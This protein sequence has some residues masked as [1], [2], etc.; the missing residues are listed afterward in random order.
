MLITLKKIEYNFIFERS[1]PMSYKI[2]NNQNNWNS[3][4][5]NEFYRNTKEI[6]VDI[7][8]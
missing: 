8:S 2:S 3:F 7:Y 1:C 6:N 4:N 5:S